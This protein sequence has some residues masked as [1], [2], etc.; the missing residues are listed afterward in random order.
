MSDKKILGGQC[1]GFRWVVKK[2][3]KQKKK[4]ANR[5]MS[6]W[7]P[8][9]RLLRQKILLAVINMFKELNETMPKE[10]KESI[11]MMSYQREC[12]LP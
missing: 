3:N 9:F 8:R 12:E 6:L 5:K 2:Q 7:E 11:R 1:G 10:L 4:T